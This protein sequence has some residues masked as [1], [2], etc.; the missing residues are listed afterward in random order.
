MARVKRQRRAGRPPPPPRQEHASRKDHEDESEEMDSAARKKAA[1]EAKKKADR[2]VWQSSIGAMLES[3]T[4]SLTRCSLK[5][6]KSCGD[7]EPEFFV[8]DPMKEQSVEV[9]P[10]DFA[11]LASPAATNSSI[12]AY[13]SHQRVQTHWE[14]PLL[15]AD[16]S[17]KARS[18][19]SC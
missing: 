16:V 1:L 19:T 17:R 14:D 2:Y 8:P 4:L 10:W 12:S 9:T 15:G 7:A 18:S 5:Q 3:W 6:S 13:Y 11:C